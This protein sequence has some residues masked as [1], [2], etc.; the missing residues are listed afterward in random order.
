M[1]DVL[2]LYFSKNIEDR[3][4]APPIIVT[5]TVN[6][7]GSKAFREFVG[8]GVISSNQRLIH[9]YNENMNVFSNFQYEVALLHLYPDNEFDWAWID[10]RRD[11]DIAIKDK[12][13]RAPQSWKTWVEKGSDHID[14]IRF[15]INSTYTESVDSQK[16]L[17]IKEDDIIKKLLN[18]FYPYEGKNRNANAIRF[19]SMSAFIAQL[20]FEESGYFYR[21]GWITKG[22]GDRGVDFVG[23]LEIGNDHFSKNTLIVLGQ[24]KRYSGLINGESLTRIASRMTRGYMGVVVTLDAFSVAGQREVK[25]DR[26]P[27]IMING[28]KVAQLLLDYISKTKNNLQNIVDE[29]DAWMRNNTKGHHNYEAVYHMDLG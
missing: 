26:L 7:N 6:I 28:K 14:D 25:D 27:I 5:R 9:Q 2:P 11:K 13:E 18:E 24:S 20:Y 22:T 10:D 3:Y 21:T 1:L 16:K 15:K 29:R 8:F 23:R 19:E 4:K 17:S 12:I